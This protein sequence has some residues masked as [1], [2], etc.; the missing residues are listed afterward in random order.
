MGAMLNSNGQTSA[1]SAR[2]AI[3]EP[4]GRVVVLSF[5]DTSFVFDCLNDPFL[6]ALL[7]GQCHHTHL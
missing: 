1:K 6:R 5:Q 2:V 4:C 7:P 3:Q